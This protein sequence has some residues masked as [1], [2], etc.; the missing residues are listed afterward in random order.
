MAQDLDERERRRIQTE[1]VQGVSVRTIAGRHGL[2]KSA[3]GR[4]RQAMGRKLATLQAAD[5]T[6]RVERMLSMLGRI[7][8]ETRRV[9][10]LCIQA[11]DYSTALRA[12]ARHERQLGMLGVLLGQSGDSRD[13]IDMNAREEMEAQALERVQTLLMQSLEGHPEA[14]AILAKAIF[15]AEQQQ[16]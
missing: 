10:K 2:S 12:L 15:L 13:V 6:E 4:M 14:K 1:L 7:S 11:K 16:D 9:Y 8:V 5:Q 3:V